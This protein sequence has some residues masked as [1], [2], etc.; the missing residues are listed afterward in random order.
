MPSRL[1]KT[2]K[3]KRICNTEPQMNASDIIR[4]QMD[5]MQDNYRNSGIRMA[6]RYASKENKSNTGPYNRFASMVKNDIYKHLLNSIRWNFVKGSIRKWK[7]EKYSRMVKVKSSYD[8]RDYIYQFTLS[9]QIPTLFW[10][11]DSVQLI[12]GNKNYYKN[13][14][15]GNLRICSRNPMTGWFRDGYCKTDDNDKGTHTICATMDQ[16]FLD[17]TAKKNNDL[18][19]V[20]KAG[21][22]WCLCEYRWN[23]AYKDGKAPKVIKNATN[24]KTKSSIKD[25]IRKF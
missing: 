13:M 1:C 24:M 25:N 14:D 2:V 6:Y 10:R 17:Y 19:S 7:D 20:V 9:R 8:N 4:L 15:G 23:Q 22:N 12:E 21:E 3:N 11:T 18:S 16:D 5:A